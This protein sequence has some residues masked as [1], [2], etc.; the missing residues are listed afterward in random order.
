MYMVTANF[1]FA[2]ASLP[3]NSNVKPAMAISTP[4]PHQTIAT[5]LDC[6]KI[7]QIPAENLFYLTLAGINDSNYNI[8]EL[9]SKTPSVLFK[10]YTKEFIV[11]ISARDAKSSYMKILPV[12]NIYNFSESFVR[13]IFSY[14]EI[15]RNSFA[16]AI[17]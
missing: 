3:Q 15:N 17:E 12:D 10:A 8:L 16:S 1:G 2:E 5:Y 6:V 4:T 14:I 13:R 9:Q 11:I 7:F